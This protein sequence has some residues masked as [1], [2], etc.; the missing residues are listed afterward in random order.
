MIGRLLAWLKYRLD[1]LFDHEG[2]SLCVS[3]RN[4]SSRDSPSKLSGPGARA[5]SR[6]GRARTCA[7]SSNSASTLCSADQGMLLLFEADVLKP[8][9][10][11][12]PHPDK[13]EFRRSLAAAPHRGN[14]SGRA[15][16]D[17]QTAHV[18]DVLN[19]PEFTN[20]SW[21]QLTGFRAMLRL[22][23]G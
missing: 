12:G 5:S 13:F 4:R 14:L 6:G 11:F 3:P 17:G 19:D 22:S 15:V 20:N 10:Y 23:R 1:K 16:L 9:S 7:S 21:Q 2:S 8:H 18:A